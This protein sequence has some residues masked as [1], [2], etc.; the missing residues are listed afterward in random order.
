[1][2]VNEDR[3]FLSHRKD[4]AIRASQQ[5]YDVHIVCKDTGRRKERESL[6]LTM[7]D[8]PINPT[9]N[10]M[11]EE[12]RTFFFLYRLYKND[13]PDI[14]HH[15][16]IK[17]I[18]WGGLAARLTKIHG[19]VNAVSG[20]GVLFSDDDFGLMAK[21]VLR[22]MRF[23]NHRKNISVIFQNHEDMQ[24]FVDSK[25]VAA[26]SCDFIKGSGV[27]LDVFQYTPEPK[28][29]PIKIIFT[30]R[31]VKEKGVLV[32]IEAAELL[33]NEMQDKVVFL[34]C[35][36]LTNNPK[37]ISRK[38][39]ESK[40]D[41]RYLQWLGHCENTRELLMQS[42]IMAFPSYYRE[43]VPLSLIEA[44][45]VG[46]PIVTTHSYG[47]KDAV[48]DGENGF[49]VPVKDS[50]ALADKLRILINDRQ[51]RIR[52]GKK[53]RAKAEQ[54]FSIQDVVDKHLAIYKRLTTV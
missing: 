32:L 26:S 36:G 3:F 30:G 25:I 46:L 49:I 4:I 54:E 13:R 22:V 17:D 52:M 5:G 8:M 6:G 37:G 29:M 47:C 1:M 31:M 44:N 34:L 7:I 50:Q 16:G 51:L 45:A 39:L 43:G 14:V 19:V 12:L 24:L 20:L 33:R 41:G 35:G 10:N 42:H 40:C 53:G 2:V 28:E 48:D 23:S 27:N 11:F 15:V 38:E 9:G 21:M 18:L